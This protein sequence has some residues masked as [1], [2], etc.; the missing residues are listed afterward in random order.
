MRTYTFQQLLCV[1]ASSLTLTVSPAQAAPG[2]K[3][4][5]DAFQ[6]QAS[7]TGYDIRIRQC[8]GP[9]LVQVW[10]HKSKKPTQTI[11]LP[12]IWQFGDEAPVVFEDY[13]SD[14]VGDFALRTDLKE[15]VY[16]L[17]TRNGGF[18]RNDAL[19]RLASG[20][21]ERPAVE[22][23]T[24]TILRVEGDL[25][26]SMTTYAFHDTDIVPLKRTRSE[27]DSRRGRITTFDERW[28]DNAWKIEHVSD[29]RQSGFCED[30]LLDAAQGTGRFSGALLTK[31]CADFPGDGS[32]A[33]IAFQS[34]V[35]LDLILVRLSDGTRI[36]NYTTFD[37]PA[38]QGTQISIGQ[39]SF[40]LASGVPTI[41]LHTEHDAPDGSLLTRQML[42]V[43]EGARL[44]PI[45]DGLI[46][47]ATDGSR[48][49]KRWPLPPSE[50]GG[51]RPHVLRVKEL[52][53]PGEG[54]EFIERVLE[55]PFDGVHYAVPADIHIKR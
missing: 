53:N 45:M 7:G 33:L 40:D 48:S 30:S 1:L 54:Q 9:A 52:V 31:D 15:F 19:T 51:S 22:N 10:P 18:Q 39:E 8:D 25:A 32:L 24:I 4:P 41:A 55:L 11:K 36:A 21:Y 5:K 23:G 27:L 16:Y 34:T 12:S 17:G 35:G 50:P 3:K 43:R 47:S 28:N 13:N 26:P 20:A 14:G 49:V 44:V 29:Y 2:C 42:L 6:S 37:L 46:T 38:K